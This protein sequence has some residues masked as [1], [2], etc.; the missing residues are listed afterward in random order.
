[1]DQGIQAFHKQRY[2]PY[3]FGYEKAKLPNDILMLLRCVWV[4]ASNNQHK[5]RCPSEAHR[6]EPVVLFNVLNERRHL[7]R[8]AR[9]PIGL[10]QQVVDDINAAG[11]QQRKRLVE[12]AE[13]SGQG[14]GV[15]Q[16]ELP[17]SRSAQKCSTIHHVKSYA[18]IGTQMPLGHSDYSRVSIDGIECRCR[19][20]ARQQPRGAVARPVSNSK[21]LPP[22]F[23]AASVANSAP[24]LASEI[25]SNDM[26]SVAAV[27]PRIADG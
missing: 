21:M 24:T 16:I 1:M 10:W 7:W 27:M 19:I 26:A 14:I 8:V 4:S 17:R 20:H 13:L 11:P 9:R 6:C 23:D 18:V 5:P 22:G 15:D 12:V 3:T 25:M 2:L